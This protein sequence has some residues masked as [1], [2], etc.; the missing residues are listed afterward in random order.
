MI[1]MCISSL[2]RTLIQCYIGN[3]FQQIYL[4]FFSLYSNSALFICCDDLLNMILGLYKKLS[5]SF[6]FWKLSF[7]C[8]Q[9]LIN[10]RSIWYLLNCLLLP[11]IVFNIFPGHMV[12]T[13]TFESNNS[14]LLIVFSKL[15]RCQ[16]YFVLRQVAWT[17]SI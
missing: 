15:T 9:K 6:F 1:N 16:C 10:A 7:Y 3:L 8:G 14:E 11:V 5:V 17:N 4:I 12:R 2:C 13:D